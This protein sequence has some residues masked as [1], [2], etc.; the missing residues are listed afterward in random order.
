MSE[1]VGKMIEVY[2]QRTD[3]AVKMGKEMAR[4]KNELG[5]PPDMFLDKLSK[6]HYLDVDDKLWI[7]S[8]YCDEM[9]QHKR[10]SGAGEKALD[11]TRKQNQVILQRLL[12]TGEMGIYL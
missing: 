3:E 5:F 1:L 9:I 8:S 11:R 10:A 4:F 2:R 12:D 7:A 6:T